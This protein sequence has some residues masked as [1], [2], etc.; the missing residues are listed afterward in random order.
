M[1]AVGTFTKSRCAVHEAGNR[2]RAD[3]LNQIL[4]SRNRPTTVTSVIE[5]RIIH[6][7]TMTIL[8]RRQGSRRSLE[9]LES[10]RLLDRETTM[11]S[12]PQ[13][14]AYS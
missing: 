8:R 11:P 7:D 6:L 12:E 13:V 14:L 3:P 4:D 1:T 10:M 2:S 9:T 5:R